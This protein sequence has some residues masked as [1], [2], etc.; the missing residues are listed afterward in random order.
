MEHHPA[1]CLDH[2]VGGMVGDCAPE[3]PSD[4]RTRFLSL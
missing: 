1:E 3:G 2:D 4:W